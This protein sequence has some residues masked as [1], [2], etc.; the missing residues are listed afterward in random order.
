MAVARL[1]LVGLACVG[2]WVGQTEQAG[3][4]PLSK[5]QVSCGVDPGAIVRDGKTW[6]FRTSSNHCPGGVWKQ[7][8]E[9]FTDRI[10]PTHKGAYL[11]SATV[12]MEA[13][14]NEKF[15]IFQIHDGRR[16]CAPPLKVDVL[17]SGRIE[18]TSDLK[19][20]P[21]ESC[22][23]GALGRSASSKVIRRDGTRHLLEVVIDFDGRGGF[24]AFV[25]VDKKLQ[26]SGT[27]KPPVGTRY[28]QSEFFFFKH[29]VYS[30]RIFPYVLTSQDMKVKKVRLK[31]R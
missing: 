8:A 16:G 15:D 4:T 10:K 26:V 1:F 11:F 25:S 30:Q 14:T 23:R 24:D 22:E 5:W 31:N 7:R 20:G 28:F 6:V 17:P 2:L 3:A 19:T 21:G 13:G 12:A 29:G 18:L 27:Y 9:I